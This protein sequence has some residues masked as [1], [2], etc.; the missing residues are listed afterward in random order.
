[1]PER[2]QFRHPRWTIARRDI[3]SLSREK[4]IIL[5]L[6]IQLFIAGFSSFLVVGLSSPYDPGSVDGEIVNVGA[7]GESAALVNDI[8]IDTSAGLVVS[9]YDQRD[10]AIADFANER[11]DA[12]ITARPVPTEQGHRIDVDV[13]VPEEDIQTTPVV[14]SIRELLMN[15]ESHERGVRA[16]YLDV[17]PVEVPTDGDGS[18]DTTQF[19]GFAYTILIP[20]LLFLPPFISGSLVVDS[21]TEEIERGTLELLRTSPAG[22]VDII[23]GKAFGMVT[24]APL[25]AVLW[26]I[27]LHLNGIP[28]GNPIPLLVLVTAV[29]IIAVTVG[30]V[31]AMLTGQRR[32]AQFIYSMLMILLFGAAAILPEHPISTVVK[33]SV[34]S[35]TL[36]TF[37]HVALL[38]LFATAAYILLRQYVAQV[39]PET[40]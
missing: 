15:L 8:S 27:L 31:L 3:S 12:V 19:F 24:L 4:T 11:L 30:V 29:T 14:V 39:D 7:T 10:D 17:T 2:D 16:G 5:A 35:A 38:V 33:L 21:V 20:I 40:L 6:L 1:M 34:D 9:T 26:I 28:I 23:D 37:A 32:R 22:L 18:G 25:Q 13:I 36:S